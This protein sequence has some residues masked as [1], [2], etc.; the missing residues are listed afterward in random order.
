MWNSLEVLN[1][2]IFLFL[3]VETIL[4]QTFPRASL[5][6][7]HGSHGVVGWAVGPR[8][9]TIHRVIPAMQCTQYNNAGLCPETL[10]LRSCNTHSC[11]TGV[12]FWVG[13]GLSLAAGAA[14]RFVDGVFGAL[15]GGRGG[16]GGGGGSRCATIRFWWFFF[17]ST[18]KQLLKFSSNAE[19]EREE[20]INKTEQQNCKLYL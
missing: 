18:F 11:L 14:V 3:L 10:C 1:V 7:H 15:R 20:S 8:N 13:G 6:A 17:S 12:V 2:H 9:R 16:T 19:S 5:T 4:E